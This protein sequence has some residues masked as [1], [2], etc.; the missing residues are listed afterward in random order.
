MRSRNTRFQLSWP[1]RLVVGG[2]RSSHILEDQV[3]KEESAT[4]PSLVESMCLRLKQVC[5]LGN[6]SLFP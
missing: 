2:L 3:L 6:R 4:N 1:C 5:E